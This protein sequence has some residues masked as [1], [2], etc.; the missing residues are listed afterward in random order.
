VRHIPARIQRRVLFLAVV[1]LVAGCMLL[2]T[3]SA[4]SRPR[5]P[6]PVFRAVRAQWPTRAERVK[7]F[8]VIACE[9]GNTYS[10]RARNGQY[11]GLFQMGAY[12]RARYGHGPTPS[13]QARA[14]HAYYLD[15]GWS[16]W[17]CA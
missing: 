5:V 12:A 11:L 9:T 1:L 2:L 4:D 13:R 6:A 14:A 7:A 15:A 10:T 8:D 16:P 3:Q 17:T